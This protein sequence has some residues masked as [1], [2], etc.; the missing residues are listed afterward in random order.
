MT[1][2]TIRVVECAVCGQQFELPAQRGRHE[3]LVHRDWHR[4]EELRQERL[5]ESRQRWVD[6]EGHMANWLRMSNHHAAR[7]GN[8]P[9]PLNTEL[10]SG[11]CVYC[12]GRATGW[13]HV[14]PMSRGGRHAVDNLVPACKPCNSAKQ[15]T[16]PSLIHVPNWLSIPCGWCWLPV[17][18]RRST[19]LR[20]TYVACSHSHLNLIR[21]WRGRPFG[22]PLFVGPRTKLE[23]VA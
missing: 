13:D 15:D 12:G 9:L 10:P 6:R 7:W 21:R 18:R 17:Q 5:R 3:R 16:H 20:V 14:M 19:L 4:P 11:P 1:P 22:D 23:G 2:D 8:E